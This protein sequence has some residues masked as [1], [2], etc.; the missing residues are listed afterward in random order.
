MIT[1][2]ENRPAQCDGYEV[3]AEGIHS[4]LLFSA[5]S[6]VHLRLRRAPAIDDVLEVKVVV[7]GFELCEGLP[8]VARWDRGNSG[9]AS[10]TAS[11]THK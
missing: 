7:D 10:A 5:E 8:F 2:S 9:E 6:G 3:V 4:F 11:E 1:S